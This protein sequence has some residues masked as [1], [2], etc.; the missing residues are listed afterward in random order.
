MPTLSQPREQSLSGTSEGLSSIIQAKLERSHGMSTENIGEEQNLSSD[1]NY[2][3]RIPYNPTPIPESWSSIE[4]LLGESNARNDQISVQR[5]QPAIQRYTNR[6]SE[7]DNDGYPEVIKAKQYQTNQQTFSKAPTAKTNHMS[8]SSS[9]N[10]IAPI[11]AKVEQLAG[12]TQTASISHPANKP[13]QNEDKSDKLEML[14]Q[15]IYSYLRQRLEIERERHGRY[16]S[17]RLPW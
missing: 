15:E 1:D 3:T 2:S 16:G 7:E 13:F 9:A 12:Q 11:Q 5:S 10:T 17:G 6:M 14:A 8:A 4:E